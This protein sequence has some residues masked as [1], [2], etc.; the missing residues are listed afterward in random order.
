MDPFL[1]RTF[2]ETLSKGIDPMT[3]RVLSPNDS[4]SKEAIQDA[5][6]EVLAHC[7]IESTEQYCVRINEAKKTARAEKKAKA[8]KM[9]PNSGTPWTS[10][11]ESELLSMH[12]RG[13]NIYHIANILKR[14]PGGISDKLKSLQ[15]APILRSKKPDKRSIY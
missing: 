7:T 6:M 5:L 12:R 9:Y 2:I 3:G 1:A 11:E 8:K 15:C 14:T 4:C 13:M 10:Q